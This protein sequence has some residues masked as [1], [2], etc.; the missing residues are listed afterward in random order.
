M[1]NFYNLQQPLIFP[2]NRH[3]ISGLSIPKAAGNSI[4]TI[5]KSLVQIDV[6][7]INPGKAVKKGNVFTASSG[8]EYGYHDDILYPISG[9]GI[10]QL[11]SQEY[12][13]LKQL[14]NAPNKAQQII[15]HLVNKNIMDN[16]RA[17]LIKQLA[18]LFGFIS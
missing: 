10:E 5:E 11:S 8:R 6:D 7:E 3:F 15:E 9:E 4:F 17:E 1:T 16:D 14:K 18:I 13:L 2:C 12:K